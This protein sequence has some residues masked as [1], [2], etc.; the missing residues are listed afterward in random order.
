MQHAGMSS[1]SLRADSN[2]GGRVVLFRITA[3]RQIKSFVIF[4]VSSYPDGYDAIA[5]ANANSA[6]SDRRYR[7]P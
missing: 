5:Q 4:L 7:P 2:V 1:N 3:D 6:V